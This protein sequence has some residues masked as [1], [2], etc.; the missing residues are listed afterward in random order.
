VYLGKRPLLCRDLTDSFHRDPRGHFWGTELVIA[1]IERH[2]CPAITSDQL[3]GGTAFRFVLVGAMIWLTRAI[4][5][6]PLTTH[7]AGLE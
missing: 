5:Q 7:A 6:A 2:W 1:H 4:R 3:V